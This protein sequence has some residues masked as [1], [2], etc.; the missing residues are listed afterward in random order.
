M[1]SHADL[2]ARLYTSK[3]KNLF[4]RIWK[5][6]IPDLLRKCPYKRSVSFMEKII[7]LNQII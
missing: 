2:N 1:A 3:Y 7:A 5:K 4:Q 6:Q